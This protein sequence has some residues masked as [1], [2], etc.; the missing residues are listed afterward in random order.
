MSPASWFLLIFQRKNAMLLELDEKK[1]Q[2]SCRQAAHIYDVEA[3]MERLSALHFGN[4]DQEY[5]ILY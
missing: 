1:A 4:I 3:N 2:L 5:A